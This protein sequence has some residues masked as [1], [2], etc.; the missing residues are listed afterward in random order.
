[1]LSLDQKAHVHV[2]TSISL[3]D[4]IAERETLAARSF[5]LARNECVVQQWRRL[6][7]AHGV[8]EMLF[9]FILI[10]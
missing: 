10:L 9:M 8:N 5:S 4:N 1:M 7:S 2:S 6:R 3:A